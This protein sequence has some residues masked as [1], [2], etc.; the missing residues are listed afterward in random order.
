MS[1]EQIAETIVHEFT[2]HGI[3]IDKAVS[4]YREAGVDVAIDEYSKTEEKKDHEINKWL[5][6]KTRDEILIINPYYQKAFNK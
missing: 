5:Y 4:D 2:L 6:D 3:H 1:E